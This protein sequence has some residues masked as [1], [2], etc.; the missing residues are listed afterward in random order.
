M[1]PV[2]CPFRAIDR[3]LDELPGHVKV[4][5]VDIHAE[6]TSDKQLLLRYLAG[7]VSAVLGTHTHVPTADAAVHPP[8]TAYITDVGMTGPY[9]SVIGRRYDRVLKTTK[10]FEP[11]P[12]DVATGD[13]RISSVLLE[14]DPRDGLR[15]FHRATAP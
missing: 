11:T 15:P 5:L 4:I 2:D 1:R 13:P 14:I 12:F 6:A 9:Q 3:L 7:R 10:T 8:G